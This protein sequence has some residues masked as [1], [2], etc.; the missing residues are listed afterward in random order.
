[1]IPIWTRSI[2]VMQREQKS[3]AEVFV[4]MRAAFNVL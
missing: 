1:M 2:H 4:K 3:Y